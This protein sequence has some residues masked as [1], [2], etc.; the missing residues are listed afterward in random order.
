[1]SI[2]TAVNEISIDIILIKYNKIKN[3]HSNIS[4]FEILYSSTII[5]QGGIDMNVE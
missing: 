5:K 1:M 2:M 4:N 3:I